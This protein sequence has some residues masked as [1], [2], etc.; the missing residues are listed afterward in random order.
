MK[1]L[2]SISLIALSISFSGCT[3]FWPGGFQ[4]QRADK[5]VLEIWYDP[6]LAHQSA[7][8][9][10]AKRHCETF[11]MNFKI[12]KTKHGAGVVSNKIWYRCIPKQ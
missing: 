4:V 11:D 5:E 10:A 1:T 2:V 12:A 3:V 9:D 8:D 7:L 6:L